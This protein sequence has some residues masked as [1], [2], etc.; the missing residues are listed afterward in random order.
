MIPTE[1]KY[2]I[3]RVLTVSTAHITE[4]DNK[5]LEQEATSINKPPSLIVDK[6]K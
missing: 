5:T 1:T 6:F 4:G 2:E 3:Q